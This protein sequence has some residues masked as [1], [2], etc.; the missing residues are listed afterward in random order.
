MFVPPTSTYRVSVSLFRPTW[1]S[2]RSSTVSCAAVLCFSLDV[3]DLNDLEYR[4]GSL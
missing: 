3:G 1:A 4:V 2:A